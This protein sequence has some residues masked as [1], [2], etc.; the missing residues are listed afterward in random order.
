M[1]TLQFYRY[2]PLVRCQIVGKC[3]KSKESLMLK[4]S[5]IFA[6]HIYMGTLLVDVMLLLAD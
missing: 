5:C 3:D 6:T 2:C 1:G 4:A